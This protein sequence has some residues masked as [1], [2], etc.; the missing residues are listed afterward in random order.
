MCVCVCGT[1][2]ILLQHRGDL[3]QQILDQSTS[4]KS[5]PVGKGWMLDVLL[6]SP[7]TSILFQ[8]QPLLDVTCTFTCGKNRTLFGSVQYHIRSHERRTGGAH[9]CSI[10]ARIPDKS[11]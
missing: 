2:A 10:G 8:V 7:R 4:D 9:T 3:Y 6:F 5:L 11:M 1:V